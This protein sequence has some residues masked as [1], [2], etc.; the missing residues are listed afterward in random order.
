MGQQ[1]VFRF[2]TGFQ[3]GGLAAGVLQRKPG[4]SSPFSGQC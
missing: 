2:V 3:A 4:L 1:A